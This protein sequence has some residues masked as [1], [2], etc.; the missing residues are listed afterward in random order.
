MKMY[1]KAQKKHDKNMLSALYSFML[2]RTVG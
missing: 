2:Y 1:V